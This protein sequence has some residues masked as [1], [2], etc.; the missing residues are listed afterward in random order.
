MNVA[1][2]GTGYVGLVSGVGLSSRGHNVV[3]VDK[4][5]EVVD[6]LNQSRPHIYEDGLEELLKENVAAGRLR[7]TTNLEE[8]VLGADLVLIAVGTPSE[9]GKIDLSYIQAAGRE[10]GAAIAKKSTFTSV[11]TKS[12]VL[13]GTTDT[14]LREAIE[15][16]SGKKFG[17]FGLGMNPEFLRE[18]C[19]IP[20]FIYPDRIVL[21]A[22]DDRTRELLTELYAPWDVDKLYTSSRTA[23][24]IKYANNCILAA[25]IS[26]INE[27]SLVA[28]NVGGIDF[29]NVVEGVSL[30]KRWSPI[31][32]HGRVRPSIL[33][34]LVPGPGFGGSCFPK[35]VQAMRSLGEQTGLP[36]RVLNA[37]LDVN[38]AQPG[39]SVDLLNRVVAEGDVL[40]LGMTFKPDTDDLR[41]SVAIRIAIDLVASGRSVKIHDP[42]ALEHAHKQVAGSEMAT[43][44]RAAAQTASVIMLV[45]PWA[46]YN[47]LPSHVGAGVKLVFDCRGRFKREQFSGTPY[48]SFKSGIQ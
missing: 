36:M 43:D 33:S 31:T 37:V 46:E 20:D 25:Q 18:G 13:P 45:T 40:I 7:A 41:E 14:V 38:D 21:G 8:A 16:T 47:D 32:E 28:L 10:I 17:E 23:E 42:L 9:N 5:V 48:A 34:Y 4:R 35:D 3:A 29:E 44:W 6:G 12:T 11:I 27:L 1:V 24:M 39:A 22:D 15:E 26:L 2:I 19:A 30:D